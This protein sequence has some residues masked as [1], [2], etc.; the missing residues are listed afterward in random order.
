MCCWIT[1]YISLLVIELFIFFHFF[2]DTID[3]LK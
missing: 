2:I 3:E 1:L